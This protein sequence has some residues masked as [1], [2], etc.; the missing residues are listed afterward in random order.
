MTIRK[1]SPQRLERLRTELEALYRHYHRP[2]FIGSDPIHYLYRFT[3]PLDQEVVGLVAASLAYGN[4]KSIHA[5]ID[6]VLAVMGD[7]PRL[8]LEQSGETS[9]LRDFR[10]FRHRWT[11]GRAMAGLL[12]DMKKV[13][14]NFGSLGNAFYVLDDPGRPLQATL[15]AWVAL[16][17]DGRT[18]ERKE[19]LSDP[20]RSSACKRLHLYL[21]WM[22][23]KDE[24][25]PGCWSGI[26]PA[27]LLM[28]LD[29]HI[30]QWAIRHRITRRKNA[31]LRTVE[32]ITRFFRHLC[33]A[34]P[35]RYDF[36]LTR[37]G[38]TGEERGA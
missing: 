2:A 8:Y 33:P 25:D 22:V 30:Y 16:L 7:H 21:R 26:D 38:I 23:R 32:E 35:V 20:R 19:L 15:G 37:P 4:V 10:S 6:K 14:G 27:R 13:T 12:L 9:I 29:T 3:S 11:S 34:D 31:D 36:C 17:Q 24:I 18:L 5:S 28:P 1:P